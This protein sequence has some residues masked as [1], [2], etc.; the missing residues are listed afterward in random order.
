MKSENV[1]LSKRQIN[2]IP[3]WVWH[4]LKALI[5]KHKTNWSTLVLYVNIRLTV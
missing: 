2:E 1:T 4:K 3:D 5:D